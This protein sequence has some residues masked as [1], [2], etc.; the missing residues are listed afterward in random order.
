MSPVVACATQVAFLND[1]SFL[2]SDGYCNSRVLRFNQDGSFHSEYK[3]PAQQ[4]QMSVA[5]SLV[6]DEC[7]G[8][9]MVADRENKAVHTFSLDTR[10]SGELCGRLVVSLDVSLIVSIMLN[11]VVSFCVPAFRLCGLCIVQ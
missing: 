7:D 6:V 9:L 1:G 8:T 5:H 10:A 2:I 4:R 11:M 3:L